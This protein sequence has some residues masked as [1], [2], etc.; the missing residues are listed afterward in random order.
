MTSSTGTNFTA[1]TLTR[2]AAKLQEAM[3]KQKS[4]V[5]DVISM[6]NTGNQ[7]LI[8]SQS[9][10]ASADFERHE[11]L[12]DEVN[13]VGASHPH[14]NSSIKDILHRQAYTIVQ[15]NNQ[16]FLLTE[17]LKLSLSNIMNFTN[18]HF[19]QTYQ[20]IIPTDEMKQIDNIRQHKKDGLEFDKDM[21]VLIDEL[22]DQLELYAITSNTDKIRSIIGEPKY[23][24]SDKHSPKYQLL[25]VVEIVVR[26][27]HFWKCASSKSEMAY[28]L[29]FEGLLEVLSDDTEL[30]LSDGES[31]CIS[32]RD[33]LRSLMEDDGL[34]EFGRRIDLH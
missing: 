29:K 18:P 12:E 15:K 33:P 23:K 34:T 24:E 4:Q 3:R 2:V 31:V 21:N 8:D 11:D 20:D 9:V 10:I 28:L 1:V 19:S 7:E 13:L 25:N 22:L 5:A 30:I 16:H 6:Y 27:F 26:R 32:T 17:L 14:T